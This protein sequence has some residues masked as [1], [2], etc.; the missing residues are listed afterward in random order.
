LQPDHPNCKPEAKSAFGGQCGGVSGTFT[1]SGDAA[2]CAIARGVNEAKCLLTPSAA[3]LTVAGQLEA[4]TFGPALTN[5]VKSV[6]QFSQT[7]PFS[8]SC[9]TNQVVTVA[10]ASVT[11]PFADMCPWL[12]AMGNVLVAFTLLA[13][14][15]FVLK[16]L[17][18]T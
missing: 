11:I 15:I 8:S 7:N 9:P 3:A 13:A 1:C 6:G 14:T 2:T 5:T 17:G 4:G 12:Q 16:G 18:G 10:G